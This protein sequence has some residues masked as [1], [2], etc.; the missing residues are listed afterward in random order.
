M[1][2]V[3]DKDGRQML[4]SSVPYDRKTEMEMIKEGFAIKLNGKRVK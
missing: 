3:F 1:Y 4:S 2:E